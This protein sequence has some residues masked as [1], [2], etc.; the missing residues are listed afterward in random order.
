M[1]SSDTTAH[2]GRKF[3]HRRRTTTSWNTLHSS[4]RPANPRHQP[5]FI[6]SSIQVGSAVL[7]SD[8]YYQQGTGRT[9]VWT[10]TKHASGQYHATHALYNTTGHSMQEACKHTSPVFALP[11]PCKPDIP[12]DPSSEITSV[13]QCFNVNT[14]SYFRSLCVTD[15]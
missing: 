15:D 9:L 13:L 14:N 2:D 6:H 8:C 7:I 11:F 4:T 12:I 3:I 10:S 1:A 5:T